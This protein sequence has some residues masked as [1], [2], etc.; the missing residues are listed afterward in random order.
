MNDLTPFEQ[1]AVLFLLVTSAYG[2]RCMYRKHRDGDVG[3]SEPEPEVE[4]EVA[5]MNADSFCFFCYRQFDDVKKVSDHVLMTHPSS[6][7]AHSIKQERDSDGEP[8]PRSA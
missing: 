5:G 1:V 7:L 4:V 2:V 3:K 6:F 8:D